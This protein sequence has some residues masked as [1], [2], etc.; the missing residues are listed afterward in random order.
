MILD[1]DQETFKHIL[2]AFRKHTYPFYL[3]DH[4]QKKFNDF[5]SRYIIDEKCL[6]SGFQLYSLEELISEKPNFTK[7]GAK[8]SIAAKKVYDAYQ[9]GGNLV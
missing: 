4:K 5:M 8:R 2:K 1:T 3:K 9:K 6:W 7:Y